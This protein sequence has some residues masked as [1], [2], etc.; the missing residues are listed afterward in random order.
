MPFEM[1]GFVQGFGHYGITIIKTS[2]FIFL[3]FNFDIYFNEYFEA[4]KDHYLDCD[5]SGD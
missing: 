3:K 4:E 1:I 2:Y 5:N